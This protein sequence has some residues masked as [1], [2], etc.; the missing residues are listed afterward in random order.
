VPC[1]RGTRRLQE[2][3]QKEQ[4]VGQGCCKGCSNRVGKATE[5][6]NATVENSGIAN[7]SSK[8]VLLEK[9]G[10]LLGKC[11]LLFEKCGFL[12]RKMWS[13]FRKK[14]SSFRKKWSLFF[15]KKVVSF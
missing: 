3:E 15:W 12:L 10:H 4:R 8:R 14:W 1:R 2:S 11:G 9:C 5:R 6:A 7:W 13:A